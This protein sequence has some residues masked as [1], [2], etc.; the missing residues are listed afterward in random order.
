MI[1]VMDKRWLEP[2]GKVEQEECGLLCGSVEYDLLNVFAI[3]P[4]EN[5]HE[6]PKHYYRIDS[7]QVPSDWHVI[8]PFHTHWITGADPSFDDLQGVK[9]GHIG[10]V[11]HIASGDV[12]FY[13]RGGFLTK[14]NYEQRL[15]RLDS[16]H[17]DR[18]RRRA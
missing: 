5:R 3:I 15:N 11:Y 6:D 8:G 16:L 4:V 7:D 9:P 2:F 18:R 17:D 12:T 10:A 14:V 13:T 1:V